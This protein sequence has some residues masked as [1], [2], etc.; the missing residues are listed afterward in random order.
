MI[1]AWA[2][3]YVLVLAPKEQSL[4]IDIEGYI[5]TVF[6]GHIHNIYYIFNHTSIELITQDL[7]GNEGVGDEV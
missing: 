3:K 7:E 6:L 1:Y 2:V 5:H 4:L